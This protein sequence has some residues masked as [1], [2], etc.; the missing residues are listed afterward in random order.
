MS[1]SKTPKN[2]IRGEVRNVGRSPVCYHS[3]WVTFL[4]GDG[5]EEAMQCDLR[6]VYRIQEQK[7]A[8]HLSLA[9]QVERRT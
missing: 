1:H 8:E 7:D 3:P 5:S 4:C 6:L 2:L 9:E